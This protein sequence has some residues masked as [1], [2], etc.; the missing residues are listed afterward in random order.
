MGIKGKV[1]ALAGKGS[2]GKS[3]LAA[4]LAENISSQQ[5]VDEHGNKRAIKLL[6][7]DADPHMV[8]GKIMLG[9]QVK[10]SIGTLI[11][12]YD[13]QLKAGEELIP[14]TT[15]DEFMDAA[16]AEQV[17][18]HLPGFDL[19]PM[20]RYELPGCQCAVNRAANNALDSLMDRY[21]V[22]LIDNEAGIEHIGRY[23]NRIDLLI[24]VALPNPLYIDVANSVLLRAKETKRD[25]GRV[26]IVFNMVKSM[27]MT[28]ER[29]TQI[30][31]QLHT[32][33]S[34]INGVLAFSEKIEA[35]INAGTPITQIDHNTKAFTTINKYYNQTVKP[36]ITGENGGKSNVL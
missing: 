8:L 13:R 23:N 17:L 27:E 16:I 33:S 7:V 28:S 34:S 31:T 22:I 10:K 15:R 5:F 11:S 12:E 29:I 3:V 6:L 19:L 36:M 14:G 2:S 32:N 4:I 1:L 35:L 9:V 24:L 25:I 30:A 18:V 20:G 21:D 26:S